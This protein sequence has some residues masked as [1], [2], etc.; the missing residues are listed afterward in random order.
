MGGTYTGVQ[1]EKSYWRFEIEDMKTDW[2]IQHKGFQGFR[3]VTAK[4]L[5]AFERAF[6]LNS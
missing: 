2:P 5:P 3:Y 1:T 4:E 6:R